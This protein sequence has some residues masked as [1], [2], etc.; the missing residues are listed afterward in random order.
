[1]GIGT[2]LQPDAEVLRKLTIFLAK[3]A[4]ATGLRNK[5]RPAAAK[6]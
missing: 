6:E 5:T 3:Q 1:L 2:K 4:K